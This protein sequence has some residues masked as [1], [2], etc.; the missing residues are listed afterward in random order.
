[1]KRSALFLIAMLIAGPDPG[2]AGSASHLN[3]SRFNDT[4][5]VNAILGEGSNQSDRAMLGIAC[6]IRNRGT[7][8]G[9]YGLNN[10]VVERASA[11]LR[12]RAEN[13]WEQSA[14][15]DIVSGC[16][17]FGCPYDAPYFLHTLHYRAVLTIGAITIYKP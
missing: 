13:A 16:R 15:C 12:E 14:S 10:P 1:M 6:A 7:L 8:Q 4:Q 17:Y 9:V 2:V 3:A 5:A 11:G